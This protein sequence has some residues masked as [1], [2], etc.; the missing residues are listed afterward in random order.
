[1]AKVLAEV[2]EV[3]E[4]DAYVEAKQRLDVARVLVRMQ[5]K[6]PFQATIPA[7][8]DGSD[9]V[10][11]VA[12]DTTSLDVSKKIHCNPAW[13]PPSPFSTQPNT[14][15]TGGVLH[16][17]AFSGDEVSDGASDDLISGYPEDWDAFPASTSRRDQ[18]VRTLAR[19]CSDQSDTLADV[20][21]VQ[22]DN[23]QISQGREEEVA[24]TLPNDKLPRNGDILNGVE[25]SAVQGI[26]R[27][28]KHSVKG[29]LIDQAPLTYTMEDIQSRSE[30][31]Y[32]GD[33]GEVLPHHL[34]VT[35]KDNDASSQQLSKLVNDEMG[36]LPS[37]ISSVTKV[38]VR[39][40]EVMSSKSK[41]QQVMDPMVDCSTD[42]N[43]LS[44]PPLQEKTE[45]IP[46]STDDPL[47]PISKDSIQMQYALLKE[48]GL[49]C[50]EDDNKL[51]G[52]LLCMEN[53][54]VM[55]AVAEKGAKKPQ[56]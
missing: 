56:P 33:K 2:G 16:P 35:D 20:D 55:M 37:P 4:V 30:K 45:I 40:K 44:L 6:P 15:V 28:E 52:M 26:T 32:V 19:R 36:H 42:P 1:M 18:W 22:R 38:Y 46:A 24:L 11:H 14:P 53:R 48:M 43:V 17:W 54:D 12:E 5:M 7:T 31:S 9:Y 13:F 41:S 50:G 25:E 49:S 47:T 23:V 8:I 21:P 34:K 29:R 51:K 39:R 10:L 27:N 3:V